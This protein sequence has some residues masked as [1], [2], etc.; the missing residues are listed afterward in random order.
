MKHMKYGWKY[1]QTSFQPIYVLRCIDNINK[2]YVS[3][4][5]LHVASFRGP[6]EV[7]TLKSH[8]NIYLWHE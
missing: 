2:V 5:A 8:W 1:T 4:I 7:K 3:Y 6:D